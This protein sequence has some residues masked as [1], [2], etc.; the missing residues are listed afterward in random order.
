MDD[1]LIVQ[2]YWDRS[3]NAICSP[4]VF[5]VGPFTHLLDVFKISL[6]VTKNILS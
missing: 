5:L 2:L 1:E 3:E 4:P 6:R